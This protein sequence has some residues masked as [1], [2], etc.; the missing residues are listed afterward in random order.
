MKRIQLI[1]LTV[2]ATALSLPITASAQWSEMAGMTEAVKA[3]DYGNVTSV[4]IMDDG[5]IVYESYFND[6]DSD[7]LHNT[8]SVTKT[9][10]G[11]AVG[12]AI[13]AG[14][15]SVDEPIAPYFQDVAPFENPDT[16]KQAVSLQDLLTMS[17]VMECNDSD[18]FSRG[19]ESRMHNVE[20]WTSFFWDLPIR[21]YPS[22]ITPPEESKYG[23]SFA[24]CS[25]GVEI[26]GQTVER[27][28]GQAFQHYVV[29]TL[30]EPMGITQ[31]EW[32]ENSLGD[33]HKSGGLGLKTRDLAN[34]AEM[35]R[36]G[37]IHDGHRILSEDWVK[38]AVRP[39]VV[40][41]ADRG[42][43]YGYLWWRSPY[44]V[45]GENFEDYFMSGNGGNRISVLPDHDLIIV[46]T[47]TDYNQRGMHRKTKNLI[48]EHI[49]SRLSD[50]E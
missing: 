13:D 49:L 24:Y 27:A 2:S 30:F 36:T 45:S 41:D 50:E 22:W 28:T 10:T 47:K 6:A 18:Q 21:G 20:D 1:L 38:D 11:M 44:Q 9:V 12:I 43:E 15:L 4:M 23:R 31:Y 5:Q 48:D 29:Q 32:Q 26:A 19:N 16:R 8:R 17:S 40:S 7:T 37:G 33:A 3:G 35:H 14:K 34:L 39:H 25:A 46:I 42:M